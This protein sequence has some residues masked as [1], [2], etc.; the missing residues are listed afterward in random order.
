MRRRLAALCVL[1]AIAVSGMHQAIAKA[2]SEAGP[3][4]A[5]PKP[6][7]TPSGPQDQEPPA[8]VSDDAH[9]LNGDPARQPRTA[10]SSAT[11][12]PANAPHALHAPRLTAPATSAPA[13]RGAAERA[14]VEQTEASSRSEQDA[15][16]ARSEQVPIE[17]AAFDGITPGKSTASELAAAW[18]DPRRTRH[19]NGRRTEQ[20]ARDGF[21]RV[22]VQLE[23]DVVESRTNG[24]H[25]GDRPRRVRG[26][27]G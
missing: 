21:D 16:S 15:T 26:A 17:T 5:A 7:S 23:Q 27:L 22:D 20:Y 1:A 13:D 14:A 19:D 8:L 24:D 12:R 3:R 4:L 18:G 9:E 2:Q 25:T 11:Q 6:R 10:A